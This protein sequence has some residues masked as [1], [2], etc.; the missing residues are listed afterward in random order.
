[1]KRLLDYIDINRGGISV[2]RDTSMLENSLSNYKF[3]NNNLFD[4]FFNN[5]EFIDNHRNKLTYQEKRKLKRQFVFKL[6]SYL[7][8]KKEIDDSERKEFEEYYQDIY[9]DL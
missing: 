4:K 8:E 1:M 9:N 3:E 5:N 2:S 7:H 6:I